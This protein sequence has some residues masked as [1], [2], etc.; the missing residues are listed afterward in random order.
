[1]YSKSLAIMSKGRQEITAISM[2]ISFFTTCSRVYGLLGPYGYMAVAASHT[3]TSFNTLGWKS[4]EKMAFLRNTYLETNHMYI[5]SKVILKKA[6]LT[7]C[8]YLNNKVL[9][10]F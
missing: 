8:N 7:V 1:M 3:V 4:E 2:S 5:S 10:S 6:D 9:I